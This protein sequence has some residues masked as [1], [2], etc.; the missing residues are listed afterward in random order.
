M[1]KIQSR[2][3]QFTFLKKL[4][5]RLRWMNLVLARNQML[6]LQG[7]A[8]RLRQIKNAQP[9]FSPRVV[10]S[11]DEAAWVTLK[12]TR[13]AEWLH[14]KSD[15]R[16]LGFE[17]RLPLRGQEISSLAIWIRARATYEKATWH[18]SRSSN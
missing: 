15:F 18:R 3:T 14:G 17:T 9:E 11:F 13:L 12:Q 16:R 7:L 4:L 1:R 2:I 8:I 6:A 5:K 10:L